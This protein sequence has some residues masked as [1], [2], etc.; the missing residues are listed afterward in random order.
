MNAARSG[1]AVGREHRFRRLHPDSAHAVDSEVG[2]TVP[3]NGVGVG[4]SAVVA[5]DGAFSGVDVYWRG[6]APK[7]IR[8]AVPI[9]LPDIDLV[10]IVEAT[11]NAARAETGGAA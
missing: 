2:R 11:A 9:E 1:R 5:P 7:R 4:P 8:V 6:G 10:G 3:R